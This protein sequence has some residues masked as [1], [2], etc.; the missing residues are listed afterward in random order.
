VTTIDV[1]TVGLIGT[2][3]AAASAMSGWLTARSQG[4]KAVAES[5]SVMVES[6]ERLVGMLGAQLD[7]MRDELVE[8]QR[9]CEAEVHQLKTRISSLER[10][11]S[12]AG[13]PIPGVPTE[14][15]HHVPHLK[16]RRD[17]DGA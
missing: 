16:R 9:R 14:S 11:L 17:D 12:A 8:S 5:E 2:A 4:R 3:V 13:V 1:S 6:A 10:A 15:T 7:R